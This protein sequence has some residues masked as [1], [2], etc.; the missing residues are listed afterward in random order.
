MSAKNAP[1]L[2][3]KKGLYLKDAGPKGRGVF[4]HGD[5][6][7]GEELEV[8]P[9]VI[10]NERQTGIVDRTPLQ[11]YTFVVGKVSQKIRKH[12]GLRDH[13]NAS[14]VIMGLMTFC[15]HSRK[16]N[17]EIVWEE[18]G[19]TIYYTLQSTRRIPKGDEICTSYGNGWFKQR[20][21]KLH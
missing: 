1:R 13:A 17:A 19:G 3:R 12:L 2:D 9:A 11:Q 7:K 15:N 14:A 16:P 4:C 18:H 10:L 8:T 6:K 21:A 20:K 5:I